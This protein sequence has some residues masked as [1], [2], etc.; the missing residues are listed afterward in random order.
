MSPQGRGRAGLQCWSYELAEGWVARAGK[1]DVDNDLL[2][3]RESFPQDIW[4][5]VKGCPGSH[6]VLHHAEEQDA[7]REILEEAARIA[8]RHSKAKN[9]GQVAVSWC[10]IEDLRKERGAPAGKVTLRRSKTLKVR[11]S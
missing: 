3:F 8:V 7:P 9:G 2:S 4:L 1:S 11:A 10:R 5:H 6:V